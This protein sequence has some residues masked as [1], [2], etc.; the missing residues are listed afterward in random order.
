VGGKSSWC[1]SKKGVFVQT[2][3]NNLKVPAEN[4]HVN[5]SKGY[6]YF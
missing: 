3:I 1:F 2:L 5:G 6:L 4:G